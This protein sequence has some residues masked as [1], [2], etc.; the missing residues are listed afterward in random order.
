MYLQRVEIKN[1]RAIHDMTLDFSDGEKSRR[2]TVLLGDNGCGKSS[3]LKAIALVLAGSEALPDLLGEVDDW[4]R[5]GQA[6]AEIRLTF[7]TAEGEARKAQLVINRGSRRDTVLKDNAA[8]LAQLDNAIAK[9]DRNYFVAGYGAFRRPP[10]QD[11][12]SSQSYGVRRSANVATMFSA[13]RELVSLQQW[14]IDLDYRR[15]NEGLGIVADALDKLLPT[16][17]FARIDKQTRQLVMKT[18]DGDVTLSNLSEG[19]QAMAAWA[20]DIL[21]RMSE[22][23]KDWKQPLH[24]RGVLLIDEMDLHLHPLWKRK[25][26]DFLNGAFPNLQI[27]ATTHSPLSVQQCNEGELYV[28][29]R[30][31]KAGPVLTP[32]Q[33]DPS[34]M[35]LSELFLSPLIGLETLDSPKVEALRKEARK[36]ELQKAKPTKMQQARLRQIATELEGTTAMPAVEMPALARLAQYQVEL[37]RLSGPVTARTRTGVQAAAKPGTKKVASRKAPATKKAPRKAVAKAPKKP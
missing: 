35:R 29:Q 28:I 15:G 3:V 10:M 7:T 27:I 14:A 24:A 33:G 32:F 2:W 30:D 11:S 6:K 9:A 20:G 36:I 16:M 31:D 8:G 21:Y 13:S 26:V 1:F 19:Y 37:Q 12:S 18:L 25:F 17:K 34:K 4:I 22:I 23:F 5:N